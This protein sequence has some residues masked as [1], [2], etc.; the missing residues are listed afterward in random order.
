MNKEEKCC[1]GPVVSAGCCSDPSSSCCGSRPDSQKSI[2][3]DFLYIDLSV[4]E[5]CQG[6]G[7]TLDEAIEDVKKILEAAGYDIKVNYIHVQTEEQAAELGFISSPT[8]RINGQDIQLDVKETLCESCGEL[9]GEDVNCRIWIYEGKEYTVPPKPM[10]VNA[11]LRH[12]YGNNAAQDS[13][14]KGKVEVPANL[15]KFFSKVKR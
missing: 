1:C 13:Q 10:I 2:V 3:I 6:T 5:R 4:C 15:K 8:I 11:I 9:C 12:I 7:A 14:K